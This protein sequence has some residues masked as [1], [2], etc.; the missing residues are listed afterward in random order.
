MLFGSN[1][2]LIDDEIFTH[3][4]SLLVAQII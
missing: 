3:L 4:T 2:I 1:A